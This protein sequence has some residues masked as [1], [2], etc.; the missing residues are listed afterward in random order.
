M[1][2]HKGYIGALFP[3]IYSACETKDCVALPI[4]GNAWRSCGVRLMRKSRLVS[5][6]VIA[7]NTASRWASVT[8]VSI[9]AYG[10]VVVSISFWENDLK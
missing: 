9:L 10:M 4:F 8:D 3:A 6:W 1:K 7:A 5:T 2:C